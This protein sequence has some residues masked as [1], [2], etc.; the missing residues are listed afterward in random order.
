MDAAVEQLVLP[1]DPRVRNCR[2]CKA[3]I[4]P[5]KPRFVTR[6]ISCYITHK[7]KTDTSKWIRPN[8]GRM[9]VCLGC[10]KDITNPKD[11]LHP[12]G[13]YAI[14]HWSVRCLDCHRAFV[15]ALAACTEVCPQCHTR[16]AAPGDCAECREFAAMEAELAQELG[17]DEMALPVRSYLPR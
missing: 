4:H 13:K 5:S 11:T 6:C 1:G 12:G 14:P 8:W 3:L 7:K 16:T 9:Y 15:L 2:D 17:P 10:G